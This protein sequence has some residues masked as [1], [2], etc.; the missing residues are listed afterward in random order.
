MVDGEAEVRRD[1]HRLLGGLGCEVETAHDGNE[2]L[3]MSRSVDYDAVLMDIRLPD[4]NGYD[5]FHRMREPSPGLP[6]LF[7]AEFGY[8]SSHSIVKARRE[9]LNGVLFK[10]F[11]P[12]QVTA[13]LERAFACDAGE[14]C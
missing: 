14:A 10:P 9:G 1:A 11:K 8:D 2:A 5:C 13:E 4:M 3:L 7:T 12:N 6:I